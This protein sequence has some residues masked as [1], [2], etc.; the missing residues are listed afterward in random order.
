MKRLLFILSGNL[1]T[2]P[3]AQKVIN[4]LKKDFICEIVLVSR[5]SSWE[6]KD[7]LLLEELSLRAISLSLGRTP[8]FPWLKTTIK[9]KISCFIYPFLSFF[10]MEGD[11]PPSSQYIRSG[12]DGAQPSRCNLASRMNIDI[13]A[14]ASDKA[15]TILWGLLK[16]RNP[17]K[18]DL[19]LGHGY[20]AL[21]P[22]WK[23]SSKTGVP[24]VFDI[25]DYHPGE[26]IRRDAIDEKKRREFILK[27]LLPCAKMIISSSPMIAGKINELIGGHRN[28]LVVLN[29]FPAAEFK[30]PE[31]NEGKLRLVW[32]S[33]KVTF[34]RG[35]E[36]LFE[37]VKDIIN[38]ISITIIGDIDPVFFSDI[39]LEIKEKI[40]FLSAMPQKK[41]HVFLSEFDIGL[42]LELDSAD[43]NRRY[44]LTNKILVYAQAGLYILAT[45]T[46][47]QKLFIQEDAQ[48]GIICEQTSESIAKALKDFINLK[49]LRSK[50]QNRYEKSKCLSWE[51]ESLN[52][53]KK[54]M[55]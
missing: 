51:K 5:T 46:P 15:S 47:A 23:L 54:L 48:R 7:K 21:Y 49:D 12:C 33:Q 53:K 45:D 30:V 6:Q 24:F 27:K 41:L 20:G 38:D 28:H 14:H 8:F 42:A 25:E 50:S 22:I 2:T 29:S 55:E 3:R 40:S 44:C 37:A 4:L 31:K 11:A 9:E 32:F 43:E 1:S 35:L 17:L 34:G 19:I 39:N 52:L 13:S 10:K 26:L 16:K 36:M 18:Y